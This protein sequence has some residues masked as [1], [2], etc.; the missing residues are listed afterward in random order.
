M[1]P[2]FSSYIQ[3]YDCHLRT[4]CLYVVLSSFRVLLH[5]LHPF[6][7]HCRESVYESVESGVTFLEESSRMID[8]SRFI[9]EFR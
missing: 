8:Q 6:C 9:S 1:T 3:I 5:V 7:L 4:M 2:E